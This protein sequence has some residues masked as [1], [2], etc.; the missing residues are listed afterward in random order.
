M[1]GSPRSLRQEQAQ[2][3]RKMREQH[4]T[5]AEVADVF[6]DQYGVNAR[7]A[8]RLVHGWSQGRA[9][10]EWNRRWPADQKTFKNFS[11]WEQWPSQTGHAPSLDILAKL[12]ELYE[13]RMADL[14]ADCTDFRHLDPVH[15]VRQRLDV[16]PAILDRDSD[17]T[18]APSAN[19]ANGHAGAPEAG[20]DGLI[21]RLE[22]VDVNDLARVAAI[23]ADQFGPNVSRRTLLL[24]VSAG[25]AL[26]AS[27]VFAVGHGDTGRDFGA[28]A[29]SAHAD[30][31]GI[32]RSRYAYHSSGR[33]SDLVGEHFIVMRQEGSRLIGESVPAANESVLRL[34]LTLSG[35][36]ATGT[37]LER[38][39][40][41]GYYRG[42]VY[43]GAIQLV[44]DPMGKSMT[45]RWLGFDREFNI[46]S[47]W[48]RLEW[49]EDA[50][51]KR[52]QRTFYFK[53]QERDVNLNPEI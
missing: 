27:P 9:A 36:I 6:R 35:P 10:D 28:N 52:S 25:L 41:A 43:H 26:A 21:G 45:G 14:L 29:P 19:F 1:P 23:W 5:W 50:S 51:S 16:L 22:E 48:W 46:N 39:A 42:A 47:D 44:I 40:T 38:T 32:W 20:L 7:V 17:R 49:V 13:C 33:A 24:K 4:K 30:L 12:A 11:Y 8:F 15:T 37:W 31:T 53:A 2:L 3:A 34:D 18:S